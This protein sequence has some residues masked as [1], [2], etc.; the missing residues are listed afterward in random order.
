VIKDETT[1][2]STDPFADLEAFAGLS[3]LGGHWLS[4][5][6]GRVVVGLATRDTKQDRY[7][8][9][10][11][12]V[13][14]AGG[15]PARRLTRSAQGESDAAFTPT[16]DL[17]FVSARPDLATEAEDVAALWLLPAG[18]GEARVV[19][20]PPGGVR[21]V[22]VGANGTVVVGVS[23]LPSAADL[24][25]DRE[26]RTRRKDA[27]VSVI[28][29]EQ[30]PVRFW[31]HDLGPDRLRLFAGR[32]D[33]D[34]TAGDAELDLTDLTGDVGA[35][36]DDECTWDVTPDGATVVT[37]WAT[38][39]QVGTRHTVVAIDVATRQRRV[40]A[41]DSGHEFGAP[42]VSPDGRR[43]AME[44][45]RR[46][47]PQEPDDRWL[48]V[49]DVAGSDVTPVARDWDRWPVAPIWT[50]DG[51]ALVVHA[52]DDGR[53]PAWRVDVNSGAVTRLTPDHGHYT[54]LAITPDGRWLHACRNAVDSPPAPVR[55]ALDGS[56]TIEPLRGPAAAPTLPGSLTE[57]VT[58][59][60]DGVRVRGW[61]VVPHGAGKDTPAPLL[62]K[63]HGGPTMSANRWAWASN[64][65]V[66]AAHGYAVLMPDPGLSTGYG[67]DFIRR[68]WGDWGGAPFTDLMRITDATLERDDIDATRTGAVGASFGGYMANWIAGHTDRFAAIV[69]H[70]SIWNVTQSMDVGDVAHYF[71]Q[72]TTY[73]AADAMSPHHSVDS[74]TTPMLITHGDK[75]YRVPIGE[76]MK[77]WFD[78]LSRT[79]AADGSTPHKFLFYP[80]ENHFVTSPNHGMI[81][82]AAVLAFFDHHVRGMEWRRP[83]LL[84]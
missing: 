27:K 65:W 62:L 32:I 1:A 70:A 44:V 59:G 35:A 56:N 30:F 76:A 8:T 16:G 40:L 67:L 57:V 5:D 74:I 3:R 79:K 83:E 55:I 48:A 75:D 26:L 9:G 54:D 68:G 78:L 82:H 39:E 77:L 18:G 60:E 46:L 43:V 51:A 72:E 19:F 20:G 23:V 7:V 50:P 11:W 38:P 36:L 37:A 47:S 81:W 29:H 61:L 24:A 13:D 69:S 34:L 58:T 33:G 49:V 41:D 63:I 12:E 42:R 66:Y 21:R 64:P 22:V 25:E 10:L 6:G 31:N 53:A 17:L 4:R 45:A 80:T 71:H 2:T 15:R 84:G 73:E 28:L 52:D 14:P